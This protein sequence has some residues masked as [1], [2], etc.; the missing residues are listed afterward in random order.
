MLGVLPILAVRKYYSVY[1]SR[2]PRI[3]MAQRRRS[4]S[5]VGVS[6]GPRRF[7]VP[8]DRVK[9]APFLLTVIKWVSD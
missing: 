5:G 8:R 1:W 9:P 4:R 3:R 2:K 7:A 6:I